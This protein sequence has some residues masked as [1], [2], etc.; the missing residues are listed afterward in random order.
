MWCKAVPRIHKITLGDISDQISNLTKN[1]EGNNYSQYQEKDQ[2]YGD[3]ES[4][5][6]SQI[7]GLMNL[8]EAYDLH[9]NYPE[10]TYEPSEKWNDPPYLG[11]L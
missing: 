1:E 9:D 7:R 8:S 2:G 10:A 5:D 3:K 4:K 11:G 6:N